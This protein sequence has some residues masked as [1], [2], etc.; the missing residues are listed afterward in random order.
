VVGI[1]EGA[2]RIFRLFIASDNESGM[3]CLDHCRTKLDCPVI[4]SIVPSFSMVEP[5]LESPTSDKEGVGALI[6]RYSMTRRRNCL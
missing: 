1:G 4:V 2:E 5:A 3:L 6:P